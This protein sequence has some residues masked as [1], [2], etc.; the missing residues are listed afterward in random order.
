MMR[1]T[2]WRISSVSQLFVELA[3]FRVKQAERG[4]QPCA[5]NFERRK[6]FAELPAREEIRH[7]HHQSRGVSIAGRNESSVLI[8]CA[9]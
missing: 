8:R 3:D 4:W 5:V 6:H 1:A 2:C 9:Y 7:F